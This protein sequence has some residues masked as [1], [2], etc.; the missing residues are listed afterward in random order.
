MVYLPT[1]ISNQ[2]SITLNQ[3]MLFNTVTSII[4]VPLIIIAGWISDRYIRRTHFI[5]L[6]L[7][8]CTVLA[9]PAA[10]WMIS[11]SIVAAFTC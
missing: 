2:T 8:L 7:G 5:A 9:I 3:S 6:S 10:L 1:W 4:V 11:G